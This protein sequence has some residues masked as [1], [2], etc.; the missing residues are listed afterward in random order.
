ML[1]DKKQNVWMWLALIIVVATFLRFYGIDFGNPY[2]YHPDETK[3][4][5]QAGRLLDTKFM[6]KDAYFGIRVYP[7]FFTYMLAFVMA[8]YIGINLITGRFES[9]EAV[10]SAYENDSFQFVLLSRSMVAVMGVAM[11]LLIYLIGARLYSKK[12]GLISALL[13]ATN[14]VIV[15]NSHFGT[16]DIPASFFGLATVYFCIRVMQK[17]LVRDYVL[18]ALFIALVTATKFSMLPF[19]LPL[20]FAHFSRFS[21]R[22]WGRALFD[23]KIWIAAVSGIIFFLIACPIIWLDFQETWGGIIG[24]SRF[25]SVGKVGSGGG[26]LSYWTGDQS[27]GFGVFYP[28]SIPAVFGVGLTVIAAFSVIYLLL[29]HNKSELLLLISIIPIYLIFEKMS[30]KAMRHILPILP[31]LVLTSVIFLNDVFD[32]LKNRKTKMIGLVLIVS[33]LAITQSVRALSYQNNLKETDPRTKAT[34]WINEH[35]PKNAAVAVESFPPYLLATA[36][37]Q[38][39][40]IYDTKWTSRS[41]TREEEFIAFIAEHDSIYYIADDFTR[42]LFSWKFT[43]TKYPEITNERLST[44]RWLEENAQTVQLFKSSSPQIQPQITIYRLKGMME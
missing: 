42:Q 7:P 17:G 18:S 29:R 32:R 41:K 28:N 6:D 38:P 44:F 3:L 9:L 36:D 24:T 26:F 10:K 4:V 33:I 21:P 15:R 23:K 22:Q 20:V 11:V 25:E 30:I 39:F 43:K 2:I 31:L 34:E 19:I 16:V 40:I 5:S 35:I 8:G 27:A 14:F 13:L 37:G 1:N 12:V